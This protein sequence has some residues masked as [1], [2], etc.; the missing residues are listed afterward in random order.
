MLQ[1]GNMKIELL[2]NTEIENFSKFAK[3]TIGQAS[4]YS[5]LARKEE[6]KKFSKKNILD[7]IKYRE[8]LYAVA[9]NGNDIVGFSCGYFDAGTFWIDWICVGKDY[10]R[11][12]I[13]KNIFEF[14]IKTA[15]K[16][17]VHKIWCDTRIT[18]KNA[19]SLMKK[20]KFKR[21]GLLKKH[22]YG[23]D[24]YFWEKILSQN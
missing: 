23:Q 7:N 5:L 24:F 3:D 16:H 1:L 13:A 20:I 15:K 6:I 17:K 10:Q 4:H 12:G 2:K 18:N 21:I 19:I 11:K 22:W 9:K 14:L 8:Y